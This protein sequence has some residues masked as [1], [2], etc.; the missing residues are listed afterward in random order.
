MEAIQNII[1]DLGGVILDIDFKKT[2]EAFVKLGVVN[3]A[4][5]FAY[6]KTTAL[7]RDYEVGLVTD[8]EFIAGIQQLSDL[9]ITEK[10][11]SDAW[12]ALLLNFTVERIA[13]L[14]ELQKRY[15]LFLFSNTNA[16]HQECFQLKYQSA[17]GGHFDDLFE[18][19]YYSHLIKQRKPDTTA[20]EY[21]I[22]DSGVLPSAT[23]FID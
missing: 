5:L 14:K 1:F 8:K 9:P 13:L 17:F 21:V 22:R 20:F 4:E 6:G 12:N 16:I 11:V 7:F 18:K 15:R 19:A 2:E 3:F 23:L 10:E